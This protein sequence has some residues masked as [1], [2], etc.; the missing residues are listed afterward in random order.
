MC[1]TLLPP[2]SPAARS[3]EQRHHPATHRPPPTDRQPADGLAGSNVPRV[4]VRLDLRLNRGVD[5]NDEDEDE[6]E[7]DLR[8][9]HA[10]RRER[11][12]SVWNRVVEF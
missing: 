8:L 4:A 12:V 2:A 7:Q 6:D 10:P 11:S 5:D 9:A 3:D 1:S